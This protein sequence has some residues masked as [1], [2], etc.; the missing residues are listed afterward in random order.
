MGFE[1]RTSPRDGF[2]ERKRAS[3]AHH[4]MVEA[5]MAC[6]ASRLGS[7][8][9]VPFTFAKLLQT[10]CLVCLVLS[11]L[12]ENDNTLERYYHVHSLQTRQDTPRQQ[13]QHKLSSPPLPPT[14]MPDHAHHPWKMGFESTFLGQKDENVRLCVLFKNTFRK[15]IGYNS[16]FFYYTNY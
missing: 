3:H 14:H 6:V 10:H 15:S 7:A 13:L 5:A 16:I 12:N 1:F 4:V 9:P 2:Q 11:A 8:S